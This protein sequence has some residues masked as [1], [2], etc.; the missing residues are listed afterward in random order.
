MLKAKQFAS[1]ISP[2]LMTIDRRSFLAG[3]TSVVALGALG[4]MQQGYA[5][6]PGNGFIILR[7][8]EDARQI[9]I[10]QSKKDEVSKAV[11]FFCKGGQVLRL[12]AGQFGPNAKFVLGRPFLTHENEHIIYIDDGAVGAASN[13]RQV[14]TLRRPYDK[15]S[16]T[17]SFETSMWGETQEFGP[18]PFLAFAGG[19][20]RFVKRIEARHV[21]RAMPSISD[22]RLTATMHGAWTATINR[23]FSVQLDRIGATEIVAFGGRLRGI[24]SL[25]MQWMIDDLT[26]KVPLDSCDF[27]DVR[28]ASTALHQIRSTGFAFD[29]LDY[30]DAG[31][32]TVR[33][34][35]AGKDTQ[36]ELLVLHRPQ[37]GMRIPSIA[38][39]KLARAQLEAGMDKARF[40]M[41]RLRVR[42][43]LV[44]EARQAMNPPKATPIRLVVSGHIAEPDPVECRLAAGLI[45]LSE[46]AAEEKAA[47]AEALVKGTP[48]ERTFDRSLALLAPKRA[49]EDHASVHLA[50]YLADG[51]DRPTPNLQSIEI[52][53]TLHA[54]DTAVQGADWSRLRFGVPPQTMSRVAPQNPPS[55]ARTSSPDRPPLPKAATTQGARIDLLYPMPSSLRSDVD[56]VAAVFPEDGAT[57]ARIAMTRACLDIGVGGS[58]IDLRFGFRGLSLVLG[59]EATLVPDNT[60]CGVIVTPNGAVVDTRPIVILEL[61][62]QH[63]LEESWFRPVQIPEADARLTRA[64]QRAKQVIKARHGKYFPSPPDPPVLPT[65]SIA[66][67]REGDAE[68]VDAFYALWRAFFRN[69]SESDGTPLDYYAPPNRLHLEDNEAG[70]RIDEAAAKYRPLF[71][72][73]VEAP[74]RAPNDVRA[75]LSGGSRLSFRLNCAAVSDD[76]GPLDG[77]PF[78]LSSLTNFGRHEPAVTRRAE[79][80]VRPWPDGA[81]PQIADATFD[82]IDGTNILA[83]Q[84]IAAGARTVFAHMEAVT[85][86]LQR[87]PE[88][89]ETALELISRLIFSTSQRAIYLTDSEP[90]PELFEAAQTAKS[91]ASARPLDGMADA[92]VRDNEELHR[93]WSIRLL[94]RSLVGPQPVDMRVVATPDF[95]PEAVRP[96]PKGKRSPVHGA[97]PYGNAAPWMIPRAASAET[98]GRPQ[99][100]KLSLLQKISELIAGDRSEK[101]CAREFRTGLSANDRHQLLLLTGAYGLPVIGKRQSDG[102]GKWTRLIADSDQFEPQQYCLEELDPGHAIY[103]PKT[104]DVEELSLSALGATLRHRTLFNPP[105]PALLRRGGVPEAFEERPAFDG[106]SIEKWEHHSVLGRDVL[107]TVS[108]KGYL[109]PTGHKATFEK[110]TEREYIATKDGGLRAMLVQRMYIKVNEPVLKFKRLEQPYE[111]RAWL[112]GP[113]AISIPDDG[114]IADP[115]TPSGGRVETEVGLA[116]WPTRANSDELVAFNIKPNGGLA[117][118]PLL[119]VDN[120]AVGDPEVLGKLVKCYN[121]TDAPPSVDTVKKRLWSFGKAKLRFAVGRN[122]GDSDLTVRSLVVRASG[123]T[124]VLEPFDSW[125]DANDDFRSTPA[126]EGEGHPPFFPMLQHADL[127]LDD[128]GTLTGSNP[129]TVRAYYDGQY[130]RDGFDAAGATSLRNPLN[131]FMHFGL[132]SPRYEMGAN[133]DRTPLNR[134]EQPLCALSLRGPL[135]FF[136]PEFKLDRARPKAPLKD[137]PSEEGRL[138]SLV[139]LFGEEER[140]GSGPGVAGAPLLSTTP[141]A[142]QPGW[143]K[144]LE[145]AGNCFPLEAKAF[146]GTVTFKQLFK[147]VAATGV[148]DE[149][150]PALEQAVTFGLAVE[151]EIGEA[152]KLLKDRVLIPTSEVLAAF[153]AQ[154]R[155][156]DQTVNQGLGRPA[157][158]RPLIDTVFPEIAAS[159]HLLRL[160]LDEAIAEDDPLRIPG[161]LSKL[162]VA[163]KRLIGAL[164]DLARHPAETLAASMRTLLDEKMGNVRRLLDAVGLPPGI[165]EALAEIPQD[166]DAA[167][168]WVAKQAADIVVDEL[169]GRIPDR[170]LLLPWPV[171]QAAGAEAAALKQIFDDTFRSAPLDRVALLLAI[172]AILA[173]PSDATLAGLANALVTPLQARVQTVRDAIQAHADI[174]AATKARA[175]SLLDVY[176]RQLQDV[177]TRVDTPLSKA[178]IGRLRAEHER[179]SRLDEAFGQLKGAAEARNLSSVLTSLAAIASLTGLTGKADEVAK[180]AGALDEAANGYAE[181]ITQA[182]PKL[183]SIPEPIRAACQR[184]RQDGKT[185]AIVALAGLDQPLA[186]I[187]E[188]IVGAEKVRKAIEDTPKGVRAVFEAERAELAKYPGAPVE[189]IAQGIQATGAYIGNPPGSQGGLN[190]TADLFCGVVNFHDAAEALRHALTEKRLTQPATVQVAALAARDVLHKGIQVPLDSILD[191]TTG[192]IKNEGAFLSSAALL[193]T[194][195]GIANDTGTADAVR[196]AAERLRVQLEAFQGETAG[197]A[198]SLLL[199]LNDVLAILEQAVRKPL[200][201][202][203]DK[204]AAAVATVPKELWD[205]RSQ[206]LFESARS[207]LDKLGE[208][209]FAP[210]AT[211]PDPGSPVDRLLMAT[212]N[213]VPLKKVLSDGRFFGSVDQ[214]VTTIDATLQQLLQHTKERI[215]GLPRAALVALDAPATALVGAGRGG[216][217]DV[218]NQ[219]IGARNELSAWLEANATWIP[220]NLR[221]RTLSPPEGPEDALVAERDRIAN[222]PTDTPIS[223]PGHRAQ[224]VAFAQQFVN[225]P[226]APVQIAKGIA[227]LV[228][229]VV[230]GDV[231][232]LIDV[233]ALREEIEDRLSALVP[234]KRTI[235]YRFGVNLKAGEAGDMFSPK[236]G[237]RFEVGFRSEIDLLHPDRFTF[238]STGAI[239]PFDV[240]LVSFIGIDAITLMFAGASFRTGHGVQPSFDCNFRDFEI[241]PALKFLQE[242]QQSLSIGSSGATIRPLTWTSGLRVGYA[243]DLGVVPLGSMSFSNVSVALGADLPFTND[244]AVFSVSIGRREAPFGVNATPFA[245]FGYLEILATA[246]AIV[247]FEFGLSFGVGGA[248]KIGPL[249]AQGQVDAGFAVRTIEIRGKRA[250]EISGTFFAGGSASI[251]I[252]SFS[253]SLSVRLTHNSA[254]GG[255]RGEAVYCFAFKAGFVKF[256][257]QVRVAY[258]QDALGGGSSGTT[259]RAMLDAPFPNAQDGLVRLAQAATGTVIDADPVPTLV[260]TNAVT[261]KNDAD[262]MC[263]PES[264]DATADV[265]RMDEDWT[266]YSGYFDYELLKDFR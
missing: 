238:E 112:D 197:L 109:L 180:L 103:A 236:P 226:P 71:V 90:P 187:R 220:S 193:G 162:H 37:Q 145:I 66:R 100:D 86:A 79:V 47:P 115:Y 75:H 191:R 126:L 190:D 147:L 13:L 177:Q 121:K 51:H 261:A 260:A 192:Y 195:A 18:V 214:S 167:R 263:F 130:V 141:A 105:L 9:V 257:Y 179:L 208:Q 232:S 117:K 104:L 89:H 116:F 164:S 98:G 107:E 26:Q 237:T 97:P 123:R 114:E 248:Y 61:P 196:D 183:P 129:P 12:Y 149:I 202:I 134:P 5:A 171:V 181:H 246:E 188:M 53:V 223:D 184:W 127:I 70:K 219:L 91:P 210:F 22:G 161:R 96:W 224:I 72:R 29:Q 48:L 78:S 199:T 241:G 170:L 135:G 30:T 21:A 137:F 239:G 249:V 228:E 93:L 204:L 8:S 168:D 203:R 118:A 108:Y 20:A 258:G 16:W 158:P 33:L 101:Q 207:E 44:V 205:G 81:M 62:P 138:V 28:T 19:T 240:R 264:T 99:P 163:G 110:R 139:H 251:W 165:V 157:Q 194:L 154:W 87:T 235:G 217:R 256:S 84:G 59:K 17:I 259:Q 225:G 83:F 73:E 119:F 94:T 201:A 41:S 132:Q 23:N 27:V 172:K 34:L 185:D 80:L 178:V 252:F 15:A 151:R 148:L 155:T 82:N 250:T 77:L 4:A 213:G 150:L 212:R 11:E 10:H 25:C 36:A 142:P 57:V 169:A 46:V 216:L 140:S 102:K 234:T 242:L 265:K 159:K 186:S 14:I 50:A 209:V 74:P 243:L 60:A 40:G 68:S 64:L 262:L 111:G 32:R 233:T 65:E 229:Q 222:L 144:T 42:D 131:V 247:G 128:I 85:R 35:S 255:M 63:I 124:R 227:V 231:L 211:S 43:L 245:G 136:Q 55:K 120:I 95:R 153:E 244:E 67:R 160:R 113:I 125:I 152:L 58:L 200:T 76:L 156:L 230:R 88:P 39:L 218:Y 49:H 166:Q 206:D 1:Q 253:A 173:N 31:K 54:V 189:A 182:L 174:G 92:T 52:R 106:L 69:K 176:D 122:E 266:T 56:S 2:G 143:D 133:G 175:I 146:C 6:E 198:E 24:Q 3:S 221:D 254:D 38:R 45:Q 7:L 215:E